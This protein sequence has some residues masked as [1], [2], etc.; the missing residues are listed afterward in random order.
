MLYLITLTLAASA[1]ASPL[2]TS[3]NA[4]RESSVFTMAPVVE[5]ATAETIENSYIVVLKDG[6]TA[7]DILASHASFHE[8][9]P[10]FGEAGGLKHVYDGNIQ[11]YAGQFT[12]RTIAKIRS[13][14]EVDYVEK[15][16]TVWA[17]ENQ[18]GAPWGLARISHR[19]KL[20]FGTFTKYLYDGV[21]GEGVDVYVIDTGIHIHHEEFQGRAKWGKTVPQN[22]LDI[23]GNGHGT[24]CAGTIASR[25][26]GVAKAANV[27]AVKVLGTNGSGS[28]SDVIAGVAW[29]AEQSA[30]NLAKAKAEFASTGVSHHR[31]SVGSMSLGGGKSP[32]LDRVVN[33]A[34]DNGMHFAVAAG[35][36]NRDACNY[37]PA[38]AEKAITVGASTLG[39]ARAYFSNFGK[40]VDIFAP[41]LN[42]LS[43]WIGTNSSTN[44][45]SGTSMATPHVAGMLAY[46][47]SIY[48]STT[49]NPTFDDGVVPSPMNSFT[50]S[51][52]VS[53]FVDL[54]RYALPSWFTSVVG[55]SNVV[56]SHKAIGPEPGSLSPAQLKKALIALSSEGLL[57]DI[58]AETPNKLAFNNA[59]DS[60]AKKNFW[61]NL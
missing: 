13:Q 58:P 12:E 60:F 30:K 38:A 56:V 4:Q 26:Y 1:I 25:K 33:R 29:A 14:P 22:D 10:L 43:T 45:I 15:D 44:T 53:T 61:E 32:T 19:K 18:N 7:T 5:T 42:I 20:G 54:A 31:G 17:L 39:D 3:H 34:V 50:S 27:V 49:F 8:E 40:C 47:L 57:S 41:G 48:P 35:N 28:M 36:D 52:S 9:D 23:D 51:P 11:G 24:H 37:S 6:V 46:L 16:Q 21:A 59:T 55:V 2:S